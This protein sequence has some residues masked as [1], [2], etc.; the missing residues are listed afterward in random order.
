MADK[1]ATPPTEKARLRRGIAFETLELKGKAAADM[2]LLLI[3][4]PDQLQAR[5]CLVRCVETL[6]AVCALSS[7]P[8]MSLGD[9]SKLSVDLPCPSCP[10][11]RPSFKA[12]RH[13]RRRRCHH[14]HC[15]QYHGEYSACF[16]SPTLF[17]P[18]T[19]SDF[20]SSFF[21]ATDAG[22]DSGGA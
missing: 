8:G 13:R 19:S 12:C 2:V 3:E 5:E 1:E 4:K 18:A 15:R 21:L 9:S 20:D 16:S 10:S 7:M 22:A 14:H 17:S 6:P 11:P